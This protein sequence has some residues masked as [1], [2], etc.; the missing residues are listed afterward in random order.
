MREW[1]K[2]EKREGKEL[3][4][5]EGEKY[6]LKRWRGIMCGSALKGV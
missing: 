5:E 2:V 3:E 6:E 4:R 1:E